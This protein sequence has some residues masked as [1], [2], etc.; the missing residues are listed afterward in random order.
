MAKNDYIKVSDKN[1]IMPKISSDENIDKDDLNL[2]T[3]LQVLKD[4]LVVQ[5]PYYFGYITFFFLGV[6]MLLP[7]NS[8]LY[9]YL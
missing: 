2:E 5:D 7:W 3:S 6:S 9:S 8:I 1:L 4:E